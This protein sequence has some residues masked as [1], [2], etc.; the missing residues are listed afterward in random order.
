MITVLTLDTPGLGDRSYLAHDGE[1]ALVVDPQRDH[2]R[3]RELA[4]RAGVR[5]THVFESHIHNDYVTGGYRLARAVGARYLL[6]ADDPV[7]FD[8]VGVRDGDVVTVGRMRVCV[9]HTPGHTHTHLSFAVEDESGQSVGVFTGGSL[10]YG[11]TGR[12]D[13]LGPAHTDTLVHAQ[14][15]S[16]RR[17][18][19]ELPDSTAV[20]PTHG[21]GSFCSATQSGGDASTIGAE[22]AVNPA[23]TADEERYVRELLAGLDAF[24]A[25]YAHM[26][27]ANAAGP[28][29]IDLSPLA[30]ADPAELRRRIEAGEWVVDL[31]TGTA[32][33]AGHVAGTVN[34][35]LGGQFVTYLGWLMP[36]GTPVTLL[37]E[38]PAEVTEAQRELVRIGIDRPAAMAT[39]KPEDWAGDTPL[40]SFPQATFA[41]LAAAF[42]RGERPAVLDVRRNAERTTEH[43]EGS[44][45]IPIHE[46]LGRLGEV[47]PGPVWVHCASGYRASVVAGLLDACGHDVVAIDDIFG[48]ARAAGLPLITA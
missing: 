10:L 24:P 11:S 47:P 26:C 41:D 6:N 35:G 15:H 38:T 21:F 25:Y 12:P 13:L 39:G 42:D 18:A 46:I 3:V 7:S 36:W 32:F 1:V 20:Y 30:E 45:G 37:G 34:I 48:N 17:L 43:I 5:I 16:A 29:E 22:K 31:R 2:D 27:P 19:N 23:L 14:W 4:E 40:R 44:V 9:L 8:R 28:D 33:A